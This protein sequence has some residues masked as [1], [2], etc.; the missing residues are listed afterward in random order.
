MILN[1][2]KI[3]YLIFCSLILIVPGLALSHHP[4]NGGIMENFNDGFLSGIGHPILGLDHLMFI[5]GVGFISY[6]SKRFFNYSFTF[7]LG[8]FLGMLSL[9]FGLYLPFYDVIISVA[10]ICLGYILVSKKEYN[11][12]GLIFSFFG[13]FH[14]WAY[15]AILLDSPSMNLQ[16]LSGYSIGLFLTQLLIIF[17]GYQFLKFLKNFKSFYTLFPQIFCGV[18]IGIASVN[19][20]ESFENYLLNFINS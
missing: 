2:V 15:G 18:L 13:I 19:F 9:I 11:Y 14:G 8:T 20:F 17:S 7:V 6:F 10:L 16:V 12:K 5:L 1:M 3:Y 4:L